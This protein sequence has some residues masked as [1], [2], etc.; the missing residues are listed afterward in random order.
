MWWVQV[1]PVASGG[2]NSKGN[3]E[4]EGAR[5]ERMG[6]R[7]R[8]EAASAAPTRF[9]KPRRVPKYPLFPWI[10]KLR[11]PQR[12]RRTQS[13]VH[14]STPVEH[15]VT[16]ENPPVFSRVCAL[17]A[18]CGDA[19]KDEVPAGL[20]IRP[21][22]HFMRARDCWRLF[23]VLCVL[24]AAACA[25]T[26]HIETAVQLL[27]NGDTVQA[28]AEARKAMHSP[29]TRALALAMLGTIRLQQGKTEES[30][31]FLVQA[32]A[33]NPGLVG[34]RTTLGNAY[35]FSNKPDLAAK[36]FREVL[37]T[38]PG[39][40][41]ARFDLFKLEASGATSSSPSIWPYQSCLSCSNL[42]RRS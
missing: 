38:D 28:E 34:A 40:F 12:R 14:E 17:R 6:R 31:K 22:T 29:S 19:I 42:M 21:G 41:D 37:K 23:F 1:I 3:S 7:G 32:L 25:Q 36:C 9:R 27:S 15:G 26:G 4:D 33:L 24:A 5:E 2:T 39:N 18:S 35:A 30:T 13:P 8:A 10:M 11:L 20:P 16:R